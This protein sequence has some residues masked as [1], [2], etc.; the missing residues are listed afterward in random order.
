MQGKSFLYFLKNGDVFYYVDEYGNIKNTTTPK[1]IRFSPDSWSEISI[2]SQRSSKYFGLDRSFTIPLNFVED[3]A[4]IIRHF[5][6]TYVVAAKL[7]LLI[8]EQKL[9]VTDA[10]YGYYY[11]LLYWGDIDF[12]TFDHE[13]AKV[14]INAIEGGSAKALKANENTTYEIPIDVPEAQLIKFDG[15][16]LHAAYTYASVDESLT[17]FKAASGLYCVEWLLVQQAGNEGTIFDTEQG[18]TEPLTFFRSNVDLNDNR[19]PDNWFFA[20][21]EAVTIRLKFTITARLI[22][23]SQVKLYVK[24]SNGTRTTL[25]TVLGNDLSAPLDITEMHTVDQS[26]TVAA[27]EKLYLIAQLMN[28][29]SPSVP[30]STAIFSQTEISVTYN[31]RYKTTYVKCLPLLYVYQELCKKLGITAVASDI[32][33]LNSQLMLTC[34]DALRGLTGSKIKTSIS[35]FFNSVHVPLNI[36]MGIVNNILRIE[37]KDYW[38]DGTTIDL[39]EVASLKVYPTVDFL[40]NTLKIGSPPQTYDSVNGRDEPNNTLTFTV[41][42]SLTKELTL[43]SDYRIDSYGAELTRINYEGKKTTDANTDNDVWFVDT[44][45]NGNLD[46]SENATATGLIEPATIFNLRL[47]PKHCLRA[48][49]WFIH[50]CLDKVQGYLKFQTTEKNAEMAINGVAEK[51]DI[52]VSSLAPIKFHPVLFDIECIVPEDY[53]ATLL[54]NPIRRYRFMYKGIELTGFA[55]KSGIEPSTNKSQIF[56]L[57]CDASVELSILIDLY[58]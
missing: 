25:F 52:L 3:G 58:E 26:F 38:I 16:N 18:S 19:F 2:M 33:A 10:E 22:N 47:S 32:L 37:A 51:A 42:G 40:F 28:S 4:R 36:G 31:S 29:L 12:T 20:A 48:H 49:E 54:A 14:T 44:D 30:S 15:I 35:Q 1:P 45:S 9:T 57:L 34:G 56:T 43:V 46:R 27:G 23:G 55:M 21:N 8:L 7:E 50:S 13:G 24:N 39:G 41:D 11:D 6:Y 5:Y 17:T 53:T